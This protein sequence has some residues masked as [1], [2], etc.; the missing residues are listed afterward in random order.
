MGFVRHLSTTYSP[1][2]RVGFSGRS[3]P[4]IGTMYLIV[5]SQLPTLKK[6][7]IGAILRFLLSNLTNESKGVNLL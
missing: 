1:L 3:S 5:A 6:L 4:M 7:C 2:V